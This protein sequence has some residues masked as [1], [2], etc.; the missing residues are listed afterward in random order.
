[1]LLPILILLMSGA[2]FAQSPGNLSGTVTSDEGNALAGVSVTLTGPGV[3]ESRRTNDSGQF[4]FLGVTPGDYQLGAKLPG[5]G[6]VT[7]PGPL[8][9]GQ[10]VIDIKMAP[11]LHLRNE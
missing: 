10:N 8:K 5:Y 11:G 2:A 3:S 6:D 9:P 4:R 1:V 7:V